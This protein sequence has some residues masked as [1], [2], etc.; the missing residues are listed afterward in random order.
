MRFTPLHILLHPNH[1]HLLITPLRPETARPAPT[2]NII[3]QSG[4]ITPQRT[5][6]LGPL[7]NPL[8][9]VPAKPEPGPHTT[10]AQL[11]GTGPGGRAGVGGVGLLGAGGALGAH[12]G[13]P[14]AEEGRE[15]RQAGAHDADEGLDA[16]PDED[17]RHGPGRVRRLD[18]AL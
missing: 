6:Q 4:L 7:A 1:P 18:V 3:R 16:R 11:V 9:A 12:D 17:G 2:H 14:A 8:R 10:R 5:L 13:P 15:G